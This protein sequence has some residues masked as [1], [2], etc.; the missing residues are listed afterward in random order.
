[1]GS[2]QASQEAHG[3]GPVWPR[4]MASPGRAQRGP[5]RAMTGLFPPQELVAHSV[6]RKDY[7]R[8]S[9]TTPLGPGIFA[10][11]LARLA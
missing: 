10:G 11:T 5:G 9:A 4:A 6:G 2:A 1:M 3:E 8:L 7:K